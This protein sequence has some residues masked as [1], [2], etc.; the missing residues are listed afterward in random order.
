MLM[1][2]STMELLALS[3]SVLLLALSFMA[4]LL[5]SDFWHYSSARHIDAAFFSTLILLDILL[6]IL[7]ALL[8]QHMAKTANF[9]K[10]L[11][12]YLFAWFSIAIAS[13]GI[14]L[15]PFKAIDTL[16]YH[17]DLMLGISQNTLIAWAHKQTM[18][19][20][21]LKFSYSSLDIQLIIL[22]FMAAICLK[23]EKA[24][25]FL[26]LFALVNLIGCIIY[27]LWPTASPASV[28]SHTY[29]VSGQIDLAAEF[30]QLH[31]GLT[32]SVI[33]D[34]LISFPSFHVI[35]ATLFTFV[36][37][38]K[39]WLFYPLLLLNITLCAAT[40][41]LGWHYVVDVIGGW[42]VLA[43]CFFLLRFSRCSTT[44]RRMLCVNQIH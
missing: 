16:L 32:P 37:Y 4:F 28:L 17:A 33:G 12:I 15:T 35:W 5:N 13:Y 9:L 27:Y 22:P 23:T 18:L 29:L 41:L 39:K 38:R 40:V 34:G 44:A 3:F 20:S 6:L 42:A 8:T 1:R 21:L 7:A 30:K 24:Q 11:A 43:G 19:H 36:F 26:G 25:E 2:L 31:Q 14:Q 10:F